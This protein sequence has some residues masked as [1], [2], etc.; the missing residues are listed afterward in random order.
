ML[1][2]PQVLPLY[3]VVSDFGPYPS[4][5]CP[6]MEKGN[7]NDFLVGAEGK[8]LNLEDRHKIVSGTSPTRHRY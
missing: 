4:M 5:V 1:K 6:W 7:L 8:S 2:H 3:G